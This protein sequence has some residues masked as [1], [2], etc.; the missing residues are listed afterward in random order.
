MKKKAISGLCGSFINRFEQNFSRYCTSSY[1]VSVSN[2]TA[3]LHLAIAALNI[4][5]GDEVLVSS[6]TNM[7]TFLQFYI[8]KRHP[9][10]LILRLI[11]IILTP[12]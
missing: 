3:A 11:L 12:I 10:L 2:G 9:F 7:A 8:K 1:G 5:N 6:F 4:G